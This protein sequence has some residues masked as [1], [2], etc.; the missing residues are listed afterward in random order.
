[1]SLGG[2]LVVSANEVYEGAKSG[3]PQ[4]IFL[5]GAGAL[6]SSVRIVGMADEV[7]DAA[8]ATRRATQPSS[9]GKGA[10]QAANNAT[11]PAP[12]RG[13]TPKPTFDPSPKQWIDISR[14]CK[15]C[16]KSRPSKRSSSFGQLDSSQTNF[17]P[18]SW[19]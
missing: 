12:N 16:V 18:Q 9:A 19:S 2:E 3:N 17:A 6:G 1:M 8:A 15:K 11:I 13:G 4:Q 14:D 10:N 7:N 5:G